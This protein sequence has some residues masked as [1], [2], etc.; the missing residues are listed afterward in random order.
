MMLIKNTDESLVNGSTGRVIGFY[1]AAEYQ[2]LNKAEALVQPDEEDGKEGKRGKIGEEVKKEKEGKETARVSMRY[3][4]V[5]FNVPG[6]GTRDL[7]VQPESF[8]VESPNGEV[9][10]SRSQV[11]DPTFLSSLPAQLLLVF[12]SSKQLNSLISPHSYQSS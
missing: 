2:K 3:P 6:G 8:K 7:L 9:Q 4:L 10:V 11:C 12:G 5:K 1:D